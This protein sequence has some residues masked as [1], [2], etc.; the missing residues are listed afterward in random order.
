MASEDDKKGSN[1]RTHKYSAT[2]MII[3]ANLLSDDDDASMGVLT[4]NEPKTQEDIEMA[5]NSQSSASAPK[6]LPMM[7]TETMW[8]ITINVAEKV[9]LGLE[10]CVF[11][12]VEAEDVVVSLIRNATNRKSGFKVLQY[13][14]DCMTSSAIAVVKVLEMEEASRALLKIED[15]AAD[16][17]DEDDCVFAIMEG[18]MAEFRSTV[19]RRVR[20]VNT[21]RAAVHDSCKKRWHD[22]R[23]SLLGN[24]NGFD[25]AESETI[26]FVTKV[27]REARRKKPNDEGFS[28]SELHSYVG[29]VT[30]ELIQQCEALKAN[31]WKP[32][33][34]RV[35]EYILISAEAIV[36]ARMCVGRL[37]AIELIG[38]DLDQPQFSK[39]EDVFDGVEN[40]KNKKSF[41]GEI[42]RAT[43]GRLVTGFAPSSWKRV[44]EGAE[45]DV[46]LAGVP[47]RG[48]IFVDEDTT[49]AVNAGLWGPERVNQKNTGGELALLGQKIGGKKTIQGWDK[50]SCMEKLKNQRETPLDQLLK[51]N[52]KGV[53]VLMEGF[54]LLEVED[55]NQVVAVFKMY[56]VYELNDGLALKIAK[57]RENRIT[58]LLR[59]LTVTLEKGDYVAAMVGWGHH[60]RSGKAELRVLGEDYA[61]FVEQPWKFVLNSKTG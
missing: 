7:G 55:V 12:N 3:E 24:G 2:G 27:F 39:K 22:D 48:M 10:K 41:L 50:M 16:P 15:E 20:C 1:K 56:D 33:A 53:C 14:R 29:Q 17:D 35:L 31:M 30:D 9:K 32:I 42:N 37:L 44:Q 4:Q 59:K 11:A 49:T 57:Q 25:T 40:G 19:Q 18:K 8:S 6:E 43:M 58:A 60:P 28:N 26:G 34:K 51:P 54:F 46:V 47:D 45:E 52:D 21:W 13:D 38:V 36:D 61:F 5:A 23:S